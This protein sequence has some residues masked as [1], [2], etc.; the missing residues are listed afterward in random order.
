MCIDHLTDRWKVTVCAYVLQNEH[1]T[2]TF[3]HILCNLSH[4]PIKLGFRNKSYQRETILKINRYLFTFFENFF[5]ALLTGVG[6]CTMLVIF[7]FDWK[8]K[9][10]VNPGIRTHAN[11]HTVFPRYTLSPVGHRGVLFQCEEEPF[12]ISLLNLCD[13]TWSNVNKLS[14]FTV[15]IWWFFVHSLHF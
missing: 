4:F 7:G 11:L 1:V 6:A 8:K 10:K 15:K 5:R 3:L 14:R 2:Y 9:K 13:K 12:D